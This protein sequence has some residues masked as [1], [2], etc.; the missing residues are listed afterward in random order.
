MYDTNDYLV[1]HIYVC[2]RSVQI[3]IQNKN[4]HWR[5]GRICREKVK[6]LVEKVKDFVGRSEGQLKNQ[7]YIRREEQP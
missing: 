3:L 5:K 6:E 1:K 4:I 2:S 7:I